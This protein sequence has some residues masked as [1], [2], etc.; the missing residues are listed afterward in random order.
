MRDQY[1]WTTN[2]RPWDHNIR[3]NQAVE[4]GRD[5]QTSSSEVR[6]VPSSEEDEDETGGGLRLNLLAAVAKRHT[7]KGK[8][9]YR[10]SVCIFK[11]GG[12]FFKH[13]GRLFKHG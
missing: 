9:N 7:L 2:Y 6:F 11:H 10:N 8:V 13:G 1:A 12:R 3:S 5:P 4:R